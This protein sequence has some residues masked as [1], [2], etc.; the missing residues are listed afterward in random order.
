MK[1]RR[2]TLLFDAIINLILGVLLLFYTTDLAKFFGVPLVENYFYPNILGGIFIGIAIALYVETRKIDTTITSG[3]G[4]TGAIS[5]NLSGGFVLLFWLLFRNME[6]PLRG[7]IFLWT[8]DILLIVLSCIE[9]FNH[10]RLN[11]GQN[12]KMRM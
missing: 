4:L 7:Q 9:L 10:I 11:D 12:S 5:I 3:L 8:L 2:Y 6:I 1:F